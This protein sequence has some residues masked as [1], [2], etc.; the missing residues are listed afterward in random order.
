VELAQLPR[1]GVTKLLD[2]DLI[3]SHR[4]GLKTITKKSFN[5]LRINMSIQTLVVPLEK[6]KNIIELFQLLEMK[7]KSNLK[8]KL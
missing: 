1:N 5:T 3:A 8:G 2:P 7:N 6:H 4:L